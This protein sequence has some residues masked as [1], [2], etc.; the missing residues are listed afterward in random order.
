MHRRTLQHIL[1]K[2]RAR[3]VLFRGASGKMPVQASCRIFDHRN[4]I[5]TYPNVPGITAR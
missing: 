3:Q 1:A 2:R 5:S 4:S